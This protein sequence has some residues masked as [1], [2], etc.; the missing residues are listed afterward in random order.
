[1]TSV[2]SAT[3][4]GAK[5]GLI[6]KFSVQG[7][8][9]VLGILMA[10]ILAPGDYGVIS[11]ITI[12]IVISDTFADSGFSL[13]LVRKKDNNPEDY[14]TVFYCN[15]VISLLCYGLLFVGSPYV[16]EFFRTPVIGPVLRVQSLTVILNSIMAVYV[17]K[18]TVALDFKALSIRSF[19]ASLVSGVIGVILAYTGFGVWALV[20]QNIA[21]AFIN[22]IFIMLYCRWW[23]GFVFSK[24]SFH[25]LFSFGKNILA[26]NIIN[27]I[28]TNMT[29]IVIGRFFNARILGYYD[30]GVGLATFPVDN[31]NGILAK[32]TL[33]ILAKI[34]DDDAHLVSVY[35][36]YISLTSLIIFFGCCL[37]AS[38]AKP[39]II[40]LFTEKWAQSI[41]YLQIYSFA[42]MFDHIATINLTLLQVKGRSDLFLRLELWKKGISLA[43]LFASI[44]FGVIGICISKVI[45][46]QIAILFNTYYTG[47]LFGLGY[48]EQFKDYAPYLLGAVV[49][50]LPSYF[51]TMTPLPNYLSLI[52]GIISST[53]I[54]FLFT[55]KSLAFSELRTLVFKRSK[56]TS[57]EA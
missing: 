42:I 21:Y 47:K 45:Y 53:G 23:P 49:A 31:V 43:I 5:W 25:R 52:I 37:L 14:S 44:P 19:I 51:V 50:C 15:L 41:I 16:A 40:M 34:Q 29:S 35:R 56:Q 33:P 24:A 17:A 12:F 6:E 54:F 9:F 10:R 22:C 30:R 4:S 8:R 39:V 57:G 2:R 20:W 13:A 26:V 46:T 55:R 48:I 3:I 7:V 28:Y 32:I 36:K 1:M 27:R 18:V 38:Q 11:M